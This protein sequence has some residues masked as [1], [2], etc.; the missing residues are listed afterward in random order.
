MA[1]G[2]SRRWLCAQLFPVRRSRLK[3]KM[4]LVGISI[5]NN[6]DPR[7][8]L[9]VL[10]FAD[11][12]GKREEPGIDVGVYLEWRH[13]AFQRHLE[14]RQRHSPPCQ[15]LGAILNKARGVLAPPLKWDYARGISIPPS[16]T[17]EAF[18]RHMKWRQYHI[19]AILNYGLRHKSCATNL[20][21]F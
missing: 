11:K 17:S 12:A 6:L 2:Y 4:R 3:A 7:L 18:R 19:D 8:S 9:L 5:P 14:L 15:I 13:P 16:F 1:Q 21:R 10:F 20:I